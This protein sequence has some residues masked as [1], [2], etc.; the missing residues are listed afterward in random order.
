ML[1]RGQKSQVLRVTC[2]HYTTQFANCWPGSLCSSGSPV[3]FWLFWGSHSPCHTSRL[4]SWRQH[5]IQPLFSC[6]KR[7][8]LTILKPT[9]PSIYFALPY[10]GLLHLQ[11]SDPVKGSSFILSPNPWHGLFQT[12]SEH[13]TFLM[14][15][16]SHRTC[17]CVTSIS[18]A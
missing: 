11:S 18:L 9:I 13:S 5:L 1:A 15:V 17:Q 6:L 4:Q 3:P 2:G 10:K 7:T 14:R 16:G 12:H 8:S